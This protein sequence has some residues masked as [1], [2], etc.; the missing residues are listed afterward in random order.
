VLDHDGAKSNEAPRSEAAA[1][2][3]LGGRTVGAELVA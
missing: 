3:E 1:D 2:A